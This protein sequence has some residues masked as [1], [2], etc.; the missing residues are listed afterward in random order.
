MG[1]AYDHLAAFNNIV[2]PPPPLMLLSLGCWPPR[3]ALGAAN[4][5]TNGCDC[6]I[7]GLWTGGGLDVEIVFC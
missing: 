3:I 2:L 6:T 4:L 5:F 7:E 1:E